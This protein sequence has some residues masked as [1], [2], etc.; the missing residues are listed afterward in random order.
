MVCFDQTRLLRPKRRSLRFRIRTHGLNALSFTRVKNIMDFARFV[1]AVKTHLILRG[2]PVHVINV[3]NVTLLVAL[4]S[5]LNIATWTNPILSPIWRNNNLTIEYFENNPSL[6]EPK[7]RFSS[8]QLRQV[9]NLLDLPE[10]VILSNRSKFTGEEI[11]LF[12]LN[13]LAFPSRL[14]EQSL[15]VFGRE[16]SQ[17]SRAFNYFIHHIYSTK[18]HLL[19]DNMEWWSRYLISFAEIIEEKMNFYELHFRDRLR[20][21]VSCF[22]DNTLRKISRPQGDEAQE[23]FYNGWKKIH[24]LKYQTLTA[25]CGM[26]MD[27]FPNTSGRRSDLL[28]LRRSQINTKLNDLQTNF[29]YQTTAYGDS[30][31]PDFM[32][33]IRRKNKNFPNTPQDH[34]E[35]EV[36]KKLSVS[37]EWLYGRVSSLWGYLDFRNNAKV[38]AGGANIAK[39]YPVATLLTNMHCCLHGNT[40]S[41]FF[42]APLPS[43]EQYMT[44]G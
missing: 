31:Y 43:L 14:S 32:T 21:S 12:G 42:N 15:E 41:S 11:F 18:C 3:A 37:I 23:A 27:M 29:E 19:F 13:R 34:F 8:T 2:V 44:Q 38:K 22:I 9:Y 40:C 6:C 4:R 28:T 35:N 20:N 17:W 10:I 5:F 36:M 1:N 7:F 33:N 26:V 30:I 24:A 25:P 16:N 39:V